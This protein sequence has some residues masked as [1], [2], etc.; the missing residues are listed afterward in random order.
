M[1]SHDQDPPQDHPEDHPYHRST[2]PGQGPSAG[3]VRRISLPI[4]DE[5]LAVTEAASGAVREQRKYWRSIAEKE[6]SPKLAAAAVREFPPGASEL[7]QP[8]DVNRRSFMKLFGGGAAAAGLAACHPSPE[9]AIPFV[10]RPEEVT[11]GNS[12]HFAT[13][14]GVEGFALGLLVESQEGRPTK[15]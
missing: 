1:S 14:Y 3:S 12:L 10:R 6:G 5:A 2:S 13:A 11:P 15:I 4:V 7:P 9:Q 8:S